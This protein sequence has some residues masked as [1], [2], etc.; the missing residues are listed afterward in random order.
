MRPH[1]PGEHDGVPDHSAPVP[2]R[3]NLLDRFEVER[4]DVVADQKVSFR[5]G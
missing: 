5:E 2:F 4:D 3:V 1:E